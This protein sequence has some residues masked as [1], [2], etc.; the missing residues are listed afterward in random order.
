MKVY[1]RSKGTDIN[2]NLV[3]YATNW[4]AHMLM[5]VQM[6]NNLEIR[7]IHKNFDDRKVIA[8]TE[9]NDE[10][11]SDIIRRFIIYINPF[12]PYHIYMTILAHEMVHV[13]QFAKGELKD[14]IRWPELTKWKN[15]YIE[16]S[17]H[18]YY[19]YP[20]EIEAYGR[21][22]GLYRRFRSHIKKNKLTFENKITFDHRKVL[23]ERRIRKKR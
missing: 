6:C 17:S 12:L 20:W 13:K 11:E 16:E 4:F 8:E 22:V 1:I 21:S 2:P 3:R 19:E 14:S 7:I 23:N 5:S 18:H 15:E 10:I 9:Y